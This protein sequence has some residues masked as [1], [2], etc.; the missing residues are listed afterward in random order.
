MIEYSKEE[1]SELYQGLPKELQGAIFSKEIGGTIKSICEDNEID[2]DNLNSEISKIVGY[3]FLGL[4]PP[5]NLLETLKSEL[6]TK[7]ETA[8]NLFIGIM[9]KIIS[10]LKET[11]EKLY[12]TKIIIPEE[13]KKEEEFKKEEKKENSP[14]QEK[15][16]IDTYREKL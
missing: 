11:L 14:E 12:Q 16:I 8:N 13:P 6:K 9:R 10:P 5:D 1:L 15:K 7:G 4:L 3:V 2:D